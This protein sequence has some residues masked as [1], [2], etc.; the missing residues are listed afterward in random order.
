MNIIQPSFTGTEVVSP[1]ALPVTTDVEEY[2]KESDEVASSDLQEQEI[3]AKPIDIAKNAS[4]SG[5]LLNWNIVEIIKNCVKF[6]LEW[7]AKVFSD[8]FALIKCSVKCVTDL[9]FLNL[10]KKGNIVKAFTLN[11]GTAQ[12]STQQTTIIKNYHICFMQNPIIVQ[13]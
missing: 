12:N 7:L 9:T 11:L 6:S 8:A 10:I 5:K 3:D 1:C 4:E 2:L 13:G